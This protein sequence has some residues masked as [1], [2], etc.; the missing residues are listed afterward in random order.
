MASS[1]TVKLPAPLIEDGLGT[2]F[3]IKFKKEW[4]QALYTPFMVCLAAGTL[5]LETFR[6][7][8]AQDVYFLR[9]F[10]KAYELAE[11]FA[12]DDDAKVGIYELRKSVL[13]ELKMHNSYVQEWGFELPKENTPNVATVKYTDFL[14]ATASGK[15]EGVKALGKLDTPFEKTKLAAY[16]IGAMTPCMRLYAFL[17]KELQAFLDFNEGVH[18][19]RKWIDN[20]SSDA[21]QASA[22]QTEDLLDKLS[23]SLTGEELDVIEKLYNQA[24]KLEIEFFLAQPLSQKTVVPLC[25]EHNPAEH[26]LMLFFDFDLTCTVVDS[27]AI[28]AEIAILTAPKSDQSQSAN[29]LVRMS[30]IDLRSTWAEL[31]KQYTEEYEHCVESALIPREGGNFDYEE[32]YEALQHLSDFEKKANLRVIDSGVLKGLSLDDIRRAGE[33]LVLQVGCKDFFSSAVRNENLNTHIHVLS[34]CWCGDLIRSAFSSGV[35][36]KQKQLTE[37]RSCS[38]K[39]LSGVLYTAADQAPPTIIVLP[40]PPTSIYHHPPRP[41]RPLLLHYRGGDAIFTAKD[42]LFDT[43]N[44]IICT[45]KLRLRPSLKCWFTKWTVKVELQAPPLTAK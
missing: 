11:E 30:S 38:W 17:G 24:M 31:S 41:T 29:Q 35:V 10:A 19:Y 7:Y 44:N 37:G 25:K 34:Y 36:D 15:V 45:V 13:E 39:G 32:L 5:K 20:Y 33:R 3:W 43:L 18:P 40:P 28:L 21:F 16:T 9:A 6:H 8:I 27:S 14:L 23:V 2:R 42:V 22:L 4:T 1:A 12:D 26:C